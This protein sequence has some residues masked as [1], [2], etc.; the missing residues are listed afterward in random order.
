MARDLETSQE[1][2]PTSKYLRYFHLHAYD[3]IEPLVPVVVTYRELGLGL[4]GGIKRGGCAP[5][6][7]T[8]AYTSR[9]TDGL[10]LAFTQSDE[11]DRSRNVREVSANARNSQYACER[12]LQ[13][14]QN[15]LHCREKG[16]LAAIAAQ[17]R[18]R[19]V[20]TESDESAE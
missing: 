5:L 1:N 16:G 7:I 11:A 9:A 13:H 6:S 15:G 19:C 8:P 17:H 10:C 12:R 14:D 3:S 18:W 20:C 2:K 4:S